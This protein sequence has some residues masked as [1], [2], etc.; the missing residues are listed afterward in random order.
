MLASLNRGDGQAGTLL[1][2]PQMYESLVGALNNL[3]EFLKDFDA[4]P[5]KYLRVKY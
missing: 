3:Q 5:K 1:T 2:N 4:N